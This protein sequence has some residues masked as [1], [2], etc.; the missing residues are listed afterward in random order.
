[1]PPNIFSRPV[2]SLLTVLAFTI[3]THPSY[4]QDIWRGVDLSYINE[5]ED[6]GAVYRY[7]GKKA[8]PYAIFANKGANIVRLRL[9]HDPDW[10]EYG[11][12]ADVTR[13][14]RRARQHEMAV[15]LNFH[16]SDD[17][18]DPGN[19]I[20]PAAWRAAK[21]TEEL[22]Q[23]LHDYTYE[24]L[25]TLDGRGLLTEYIQVGN[26]INTELLLME[27]VP[28]HTPI[29]W[30]RNVLLL[31]AGI[32]AVR[33]A[34]DD[35][36]KAIGL[37]LHV[38]QP[39]NV[40]PWVDA[41]AEAGILD[42]DIMGISY[43]AKWS[44]LPLGR[45]EQAIRELR[46]RYGKDVVIV[47][48]AYPWTLRYNDQAHNIL[49]ADSLVEGYPATQDGQRR[50]LID[51]MRA[52]LTGGGLGVVYWEPAWISTR[53]K[54]RW[55]QGSHWENAALFDFHPGNL[56]KGADFLSHDYSN[57]MQSTAHENR[58]VNSQ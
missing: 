46:L 20:I 8:D 51:L 45:V 18:A 29:N 25:M 10:T 49:G 3:M 41:A 14:I 47:E 36:G 58:N 30:E 44:K 24:T 13:S 2:G 55:G 31:N 39:E 54:T 37:M 32:S 27:E 4:A 12:L 17:W 15:L 28:E 35:S 57:E 48:T 43:Y 33:R 1:M 9:W 52:V 5:M 19:H 22:A 40:R 42:F 34:S 23:R 7:E 38:A 21:T 6:C 26:E 53:C 50:I 16:Y 11:T 56:H